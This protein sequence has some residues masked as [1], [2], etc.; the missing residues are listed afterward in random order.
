MNLLEVAEGGALVYEWE[1]Q[2]GWEAKV[3]I[4]GWGMT[5]ERDDRGA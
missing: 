4:D 5:W 1:K 3:V 2:L